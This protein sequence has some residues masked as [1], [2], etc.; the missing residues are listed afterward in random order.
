MANGKANGTS[1]KVSNETISVNYTSLVIII[2]K[3]IKNI[4]F[5]LFI[6]YEQ[7]K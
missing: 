3:N 2:C 4:L 1:N 5:M 7:Y 6:L